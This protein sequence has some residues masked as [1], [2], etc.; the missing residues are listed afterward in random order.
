MEILLIILVM[1]KS[2][3][4]EIKKF[5]KNDFEGYKKLVNFTEKIFNKGFTLIYLINH[6]II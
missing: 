6:L 3:E 2:M 4:K 1:M 5:S